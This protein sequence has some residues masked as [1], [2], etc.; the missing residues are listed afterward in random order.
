MKN[1]DNLETLEKII[2]MMTEHKLDKVS[3]QGFEVIKT[4]HI[5]PDVVDFKSK[6]EE[7]LSEDEYND[8]LYGSVE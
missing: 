3:F 7:E 8:I 6:K 2:K 1:N 5:N 4:I